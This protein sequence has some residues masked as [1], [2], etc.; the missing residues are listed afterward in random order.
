M[1]KVEARGAGRM[2]A[3][4]VPRIGRYGNTCRLWTCVAV[5]ASLAFLTTKAPMQTMNISLPDQLEFANRS[6]V[7]F[8]GEF[9]WI[10]KNAQ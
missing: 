9:G 2:V 8:D 10:M 7:E 6:D 1:G 5:R 4:D 3:V